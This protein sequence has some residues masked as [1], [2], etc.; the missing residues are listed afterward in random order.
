MCS[1][2]SNRCLIRCILQQ[3]IVESY[4]NLLN[5]SYVAQESLSSIRIYPHSKIVVLVCLLLVIKIDSSMV[6]VNY[7]W[8][9]VPPDGF[10]SVA[11]D[12]DIATNYLTDI[13]CLPLHL[14]LYLN[15]S[16]SE[17]HWGYSWHSALQYQT[18][19]FYDKNTFYIC[20]PSTGLTYS[21]RKLSC[22]RSLS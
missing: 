15:T 10:H 19:S 22:V 1:C 7:Y 12:V 6:K 20:I 17:A 16:I 8:S 5:I 14:S 21:I 13:P 2:W 18:S 9:Q 11:T 4:F 3:V